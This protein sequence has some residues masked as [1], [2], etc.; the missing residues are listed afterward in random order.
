MKNGMKIEYEGNAL[1]LRMRSD[2]SNGG[3]GFKATYR[4]SEGVWLPYALYISVT[5]CL[6]VLRQASMAL[7]GDVTIGS[8]LS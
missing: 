4:I 6:S 5:L 7:C 8:Y 2:D 1:Y 3:A